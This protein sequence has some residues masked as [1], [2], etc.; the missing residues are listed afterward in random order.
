M[1]VSY[2]RLNNSFWSKSSLIGTLGVKS[3][4]FDL[5]SSFML[6]VPIWQGAGAD[7]DDKT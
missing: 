3:E 4:S 6:S 2:Y 7:V 1:S 5:P